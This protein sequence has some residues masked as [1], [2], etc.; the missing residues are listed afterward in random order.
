MDGKCLLWDRT[1]PAGSLRELEALLWVSRV[2][3]ERC[4]CL[5]SLS[6][7]FYQQAQK[8]KFQ[9]IFMY[10]YQP[11]SCPHRPKSERV[12][13]LLTSYQPL[14]TPQMFTAIFCAVSFQSIQPALVLVPS[15]IQPMQQLLS[16]AVHCCRCLTD[17]QSCLTG[18]AGCLKWCNH[19]RPLKTLSLQFTHVPAPHSSTELRI[20]TASSHINH[21]PEGHLCHLEHH[22]GRSELYELQ[23]EIK[24]LFLPIPAFSLRNLL[25]SRSSLHVLNKKSRRQSSV[26]TH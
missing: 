1:W 24:Q 17:R 4:H 16:V 5:V 26:C 9:D 11:S 18:Q 2:C 23:I 6:W 21:D 13:P 22:P 14:L 12:K 3:S 20:P 10:E 8:Q 15:N 19:S 25:L 7:V